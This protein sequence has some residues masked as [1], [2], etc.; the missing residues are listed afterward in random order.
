M[1]LVQQVRAR[2][3]NGFVLAFHDIQ[4]DR[5]AELVDSIQPARPVSLTE[6]LDR[7]KQGKP[8]SGLFAITVDDGV[9]ETVRSLS[10]LFLTRGWPGTFYLS[11]GYLDSGEGM[12]F[13]WW[14]NL[15]RFLPYKKLEMKS[16]AVDLSQPGAVS[17]LS[18]KMETM[19]H[20]Q[21]IDTYLPFT[22]E[23]AEV[24]MRE[25]GLNL[26]FIR[27]PDPIRWP[28]VAELSRNDLLQF[29]SHGVTHAAMSA[30]TDEELI[31]EMRHSR[32][33]VSGYTGRPCRHLAYPFGS[34]QSIGRRAAIIAQQYYDSAATMTLGSID[35]ANPWLLPRIPLY[36][37]NSIWFARL[38]ILL[39]CNRLRGLTGARV[40]ELKPASGNASFLRRSPV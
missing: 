13:Q 3:S 8:T 35:S 11:T 33:L 23:L 26:D 30:L 17:E 18:R 24:V 12:G 22:L 19:W 16:G 9:G 32:N 36:P 37:E 40:N 20:S 31:F 39:K 14:R 25:R 1:S 34:D 29:E 7:S 27:P 4:P 5:L 21:R 6:L 15:V 38:K 2:F 10:Q 28:E